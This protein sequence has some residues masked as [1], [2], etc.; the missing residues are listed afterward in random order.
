MSHN[1]D[2]EYCVLP[3]ERYPVRKHCCHQL[4]YFVRVGTSCTVGSGGPYLRYWFQATVLVF[5]M[6]MWRRKRRNYCW[7]LYLCYLCKPASFASMF[8]ILFFLTS[9]SNDIIYLLTEIGLAPSGSSKK[10][11]QSH[12]RPGQ[13]LR[14]PGI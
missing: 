9:Q 1:M 8:Q 5:E 12:Y 11:K 2:P 4:K 3:E 14:V 13:A 7:R 6:S 10:V